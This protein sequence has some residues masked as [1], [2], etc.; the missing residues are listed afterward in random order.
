MNNYI[1]EMQGIKKSFGSNLVLKSVDLSL[2][3]G[4][5]HALLGENGTGKST[6]MNILSGILP[7]DE[8]RIAMNGE[9]QNMMAPGI[10]DMMGIAFIHQELALINDL[11]VTENLFLGA[12]KKNHIFLDKKTMEARAKEILARMNVT[13]HPGTLVS[14]L[15]ASYKQIIEIGKALLKDAK[16]II[17]DE[18][19]TSLTDVE[20]AQVFTIMRTLKEQGVSIVFISHKLNEVIEICDSYTIMRDGEVVAKGE[21]N[22][23]TTEHMLAKHMVGKELSYN[24]IY[25]ARDIGETVLELKALERGREFRNINLYVK[26]G[27]IIGVTGL[28]GDGRSELFEAVFG[29]KDKYDGEIYVNGKLVKMTSTSLAQSLG[30]S[31]VPRN[32]KENGIIKDLS[33]AENMSLPMLKRLKRHGLI[34][35]KMEKEFNDNYVKNLNIKVSDLQNLITS[36]SG[37]NQQKAVLAKALGTSPQLVILDNPTQ[38]VD[39]GAKL[40]I[41]SI[42]MELA[43]QGVSFVILSSEAQEIFMTC[44]RTYVMFHGEIRGEFSRSEISEE[45]IMCVATGGAVDKSINHGTEEME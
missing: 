10:A 15:N 31:Y 27:E 43:K 7:Y 38:G 36:L 40:E 9:V 13:V 44:D 29:T 18:P 24:D 19:T 20:I 8:G 1:I 6:L 12:E 32:R 41:Y 42:I 22:E 2:K 34:N 33:V 45:N 30:I 4:S 14:D 25:K 28:L 11:N 26:K 3:P 16:V 37:G 35:R 21:V 17:M 23:E 5:I 39:I